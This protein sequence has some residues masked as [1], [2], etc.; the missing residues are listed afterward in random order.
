[1]LQI[2]KD[3]SFT[4]L[5]RLGAVPRNAEPIL[6][7]FGKSGEIS[8]AQLID[9]HVITLIS[10][11]VVKLHLQRWV[12]L[13]KESRL[14]IFVKIRLNVARIHDRWNG[15]AGTEDYP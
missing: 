12:P 9:W 14:H 10:K 7:I 15:H 8:T 5:Q 2:A 1:V 6:A 11:R 4:F 3:S 13:D